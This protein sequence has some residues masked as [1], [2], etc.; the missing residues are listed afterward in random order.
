MK[1]KK[2]NIFVLSTSGTSSKFEMEGGML[3]VKSLIADVK[4]DCRRMAL[5][6]NEEDELDLER[7]KK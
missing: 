7:C 5:A 3:Y 4:F 1:V 6:T 2:S